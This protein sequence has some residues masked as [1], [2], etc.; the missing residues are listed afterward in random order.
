MF[1]SFRSSLTL[2][3]VLVSVLLISA[4]QADPPMVPF[5]QEPSAAASEIAAPDETASMNPDI[6]TE[7]APSDPPAGEEPDEND[8]LGDFS[9][10][11]PFA[12][13]PTTGHTNIN[14]V[15]VGTHD[16]YDR[17]VFEFATGIPEFMIALAVPPLTQDGSGDEMDVEGD[18]F[19]RVTMQGATK[20]TE[21]GSSSYEGE[22]QFITDF[23]RI[24]ELAEGGDFEAVSTWYV[25]LNGADYPCTRVLT[26]SDPERLVIDIEH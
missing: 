5:S 4:C 25:G 10:G 2:S 26:F 7:P 14:D 15:R 20:Q 6:T 1:N 12:G 23:D 21:D 18:S 9:C 11:L 22:T 19:L 3:L 13:G 8:V 24:A 17:V 16:G